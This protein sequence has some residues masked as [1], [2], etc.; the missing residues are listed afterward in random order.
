MIFFLSLLIWSLATMGPGGFG[1]TL[2]NASDLPATGGPDSTA[3]LMVYGIMST[4]GS[5]AAG[6]LNQ[7]DY[8]RLSRRPR[9]AILG[10]VF[11]SFIYSIAGSVIGVLVV[12]ATQRRLGGEAVWNPPMLFTMLLAQDDSAGTRVACFF[13]GLALSASQ[14]G[15]NVPG[16][17][18]AGGIDLA[19]VLP[20]WVNVRRGAYI[21]ALLSPIV[22]PWQL[23]NTPTT[24]LTVL[25]SYGVFLAPMTGMMVAHYHLVSKEKIDVDG[26]YRGD[27]SSIYWYEAGVNLRAPVAVCPSSSEPADLFTILISRVQWIIGVVPCLPGFIAAVNESVA[28]PDGLTELYYM[29]YLYG[30]I[31]SMLVYYLLHIVFPSQPLDA[32]VKQHDSAAVIKSYYND[33]WEVTLAQTVDIIQGGNKLDGQAA[34]ENPKLAPSK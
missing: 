14:I 32:F 5:I 15:A 22:N 30:F 19:S 1:D 31:S 23:V 29:N 17:A 34:E 33:R 24:F 20:R 21:T 13:A 3:W 8:S 27:R 18:L 4:I 26:L 11:A 7:N 9:D 12:A 16:N 2:D 10:Q 6:I 25:S 28:I